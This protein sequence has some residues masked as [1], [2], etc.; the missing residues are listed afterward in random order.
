MSLVDKICSSN[1]MIV[2]ALINCMG[3][4][5]VHDQSLQEEARQEVELI[6][7]WERD[8]TVG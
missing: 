5:Y 4:I 3:K 2:T 7:S 6:L 8:V 1:G